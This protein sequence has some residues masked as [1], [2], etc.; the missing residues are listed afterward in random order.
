MEPVSPANNTLMDVQSRAPR[1]EITIDDHGRNKR[2]TSTTLGSFSPGHHRDIP[3]RE[4][5]PR[6]VSAHIS[7][8]YQNAEKVGM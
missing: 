2:T 3:H 5:L 7:E 1:G 8:P 6:D 4:S